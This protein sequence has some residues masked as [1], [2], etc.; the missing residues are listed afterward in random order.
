VIVS[1]TSQTSSQVTVIGQVSAATK[2]NINPAGDRVLDV[3]S[4]AGG[5]TN[6]G[7]ET[8][9]TLQRRGREATVYFIN[10]VKDSKENVFV[11]PGDTLYVYQEKRSFTSFGATGQINQFFFDQE[12]MMLT[13]AIGKAGGPL[14]SQANPRQVLL[15]RLE[16][17]DLL[18]QMAI[19]VSM[20]PPDQRIIPT[21]YRANL[22]E[23]AGF[24]VARTFPVQN[25]DILYITNADAVQLYK[26]LNLINAATNIT[27]NGT[28]SY[29]VIKTIR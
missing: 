25:R 22:L 3:L 29:D 19:D 2:V 23:P 4:K 20:F 14:D 12:H 7:Y 28:L 10:L 24:F 6:A 11:E 18:E 9:V 16:R 17:R 21:I 26:F 5:I 15:Y 27:Y 13:D 8:F 1:L